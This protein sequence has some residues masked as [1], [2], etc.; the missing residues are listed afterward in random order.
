MSTKHENR[1][2]LKIRFK[3]NQNQQIKVWVI[4]KITFTYGNDIETFDKVPPILK[5]RGYRLE[6]LIMFD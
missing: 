4:A 1:F 5:Y 6:R 2:K 3:Q